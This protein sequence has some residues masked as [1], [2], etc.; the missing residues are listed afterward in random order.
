M[1]QENSTADVA[2]STLFF[3]SLF[4]HARLQYQTFSLLWGIVVKRR[5]AASHDA[6]QSCLFR[7]S[8]FYLLWQ[9]CYRIVNLLAITLAASSRYVTIIS[10]HHSLITRR[11]YDVKATNGPPFL[12]GL[13]LIFF[14]VALDFHS[15]FLIAR[16]HVWGDRHIWKSLVGS[17]G[18]IISGL[19]NGTLK[20]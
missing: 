6:A 2:A 11:Q 10:L 17:I 5:V 16:L 12:S 20:G 7:G 13:L 1:T 19:L 4:L 3:I 18:E 14:V 9:C 8:D 15:N